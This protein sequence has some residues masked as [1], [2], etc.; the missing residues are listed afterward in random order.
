MPQQSSRFDLYC[1]WIFD[2][3]SHTRVCQLF[4][5][6]QALS[7]IVLCLF[8]QYSSLFLYYLF[9]QRFHPRYFFIFFHVYSKRTELCV[10]LI[11]SYLRFFIHNFNIFLIAQRLLTLVQSHDWW[12]IL[13]LNLWLFE[14]CEPQL[15]WSIFEKFYRKCFGLTFH[16]F[17]PKLMLLS[18]KEVFLAF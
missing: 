9:F 8:I 3:I 10:S 13:S 12:R 18:L 2:Q 11:L 17:D 1:I 6:R 15:S 14:F 16:S 4:L 7:F 5:H